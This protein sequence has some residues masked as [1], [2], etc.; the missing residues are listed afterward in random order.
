MDGKTIAMMSVAG[1]LSILPLLLAWVIGELPR[2]TPI[3]RAWNRGLKRKLR[4]CL[5]VGNV[6]L[7]A[8]L[9][10]GA[11]HPIDA[12]QVFENVP[13]PPPEGRIQFGKFIYSPY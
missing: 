12:G 6:P 7:A 3:S 1:F 8:T 9:L 13:T 5:K 2:E 10:E 11:G 4:D